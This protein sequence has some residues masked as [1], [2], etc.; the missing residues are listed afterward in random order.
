MADRELGFCNRLR[1]M[2]GLVIALWHTWTNSGSGG[3]WRVFIPG[4][5]SRSEQ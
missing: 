5:E 3:R 4:V 2:F 1:D